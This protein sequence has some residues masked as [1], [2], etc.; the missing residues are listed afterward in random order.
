MKP[1][2]A[3]ITLF[4]MVG[5]LTACKEKEQ[6]DSPFITITSPTINQLVEDSDSIRV[7]ALIE[8]KNT[9]VLHYNLS[10]RSKKDRLIYESQSSCDCKTSPTVKVEKSFVYNVKETSELTLEIQARLA[11][12]SDIRETRPFRLVD[13]K[14]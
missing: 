1:S 7:E 8:P 9:S 2:K 6:L 14:K 5:L 11:D 13:S 12:G 10:V 4:G 3:I